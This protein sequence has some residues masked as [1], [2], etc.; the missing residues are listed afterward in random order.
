M[1]DSTQS[2]ITNQC[3]K[4]RRRQFHRQVIISIQKFAMR[5]LGVL[6]MIAARMIT[7][8]TSVKELVA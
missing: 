8:L 4:L 5:A 6:A 3:H 2:T 7:A 1:I